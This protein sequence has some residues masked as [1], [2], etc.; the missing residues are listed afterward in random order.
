V[1]SKSIRKCF[2]EFFA[3]RGHEVVRSSALI[4]QRDPTLLFTNAGM[5]QFKDV[6]V[7]KDKRAYSRAASSQKCARAGGKHNDL[8]NVGYTNRHLTFFEMLGNFSFGDYF[9]KEAIVWAW[10]L[11]TAEFSLP[12]QRLHATVF[13]EDDEAHELWRTEIGIPADRLY[14]LGEEDNFWAMGETGPCGPCSEIFFDTERSGCG[15]DECDPGCDCGRFVEIWNLVFM[16]FERDA[17]GTMTPLPAPSIDTGMGLERISMILQGA[18]DVYGTD[19]LRPIMEQT[20]ARAGV[21]LGASAETDVALKVI[22]DHLR[23]TTFLLTDGALPANDGR[24]YVLRR[25]IRRAA[26]FGK[27]LGFEEPFLHELSGLVTDRMSA[28]YPELAESRQH[29]ARVLRTEEERFQKTL[30]HAGRI[31]EDIVKAR[32]AAGE[33]VID[34]SQ[35]FKLYDT[36]GLPLDT[37]KDMAEVRGMSVDEAG[38]ATMLDEARRKARTTWKGKGRDGEPD[39]YRALVD[40]GPVRFVG[41]DTLEV[42]DA[43]V[44][45]LLRDGQ[46]VDSL[47]AGEAGEVV[48]DRTPFYPEGGGQVGDRG[49]LRGDGIMATVEDTQKPLGGLIVHRVSVERGPLRLHDVA[50]ARVE[51]SSRRSTASNHSGTHLLHAALRQV[52][53]EHVKQAG[54]LVESLRLRFDFNHYTKVDRDELERIESLVNAQIGLNDGV[55][56]EVMPLDEA[57]GRGALAFFGDKY[58]DEVRVVQMGQFSL[59]LCGGT[60]V[61]RTGNIGYLHIVSESS[62]AAGVRRMEAVTGDRAVLRALADASLVEELAGRLHVPRTALVE[63]VESLRDDLKTARRELT[64]LKTKLAASGGRAGDDDAIVAVGGAKVAVRKVEDLGKGAVRT[65]ADELKRQVGSGAVL[66]GTVKEGGKAALLVAVTADL[67]AQIDA[68]AVV[69]EMAAVVGGRGGGRKDMAEAGGPDGDK[70]DAA[71]ERGLEVVRA[72]LGQA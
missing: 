40:R 67:A 29:V 11:L 62:V 4:P 43:R 52:L 5:N 7:G 63:H 37:L 12:E 65:L 59:E 28:A 8:E 50:E 14:R 23:S 71:L 72:R 60:H 44:K 26:R 2:L 10:E 53:G 21:E 6:F 27:R 38:F 47:R 49:S 70:V 9:K 31:F 18:D 24:G 20:A 32:E 30:T 51:A 15:R 45:A 54:S 58:Q 48:L 66:L 36:F 56:C 64:E 35:A 22:A 33:S 3:A 25:I 17:S 55:E 39:V 19:L 34:G 42:Q 68:G 46:P 41:Y 1:T 57:L 61:D 13:H 16:Q 69:R